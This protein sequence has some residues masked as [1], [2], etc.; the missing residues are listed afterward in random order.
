MTLL[1]VESELRASA[2][3]VGL[4]LKSVGLGLLLAAALLSPGCGSSAP[5]YVHVGES[6]SSPQ[7]ALVSGLDLASI[8]RS[9]R[10]QDDLYRFANG[11]WLKTV[12]I[13][14]DEVNAGPVVAIEKRVTQDLKEVVDGLLLTPHPAGSDEAK[15]VAL[16]QSFVDEAQLETVGVEPV[17]A[18][19]EALRQITTR[20]E[21]A[22]TWG[23]FSG[24]WFSGIF[25]VGVGPDPET[26]QVQSLYLSPTGLTLSRVYYL[27]DHPVHLEARRN[28][29]EYAT[30]M[31]RAAEHPDPEAGARQVLEIQTALA[32]AFPNSAEQNDQQKNNIRISTT[33]LGEVLAPFEWQ[34][35]ARA[36]GLDQ[37][38]ELVIGRLGYAE[39][40]GEVYASFEVEAWKSYLAFRL[41]DRYSYFMN[42]ATAGQRSRFYSALSGSTDAQP[43]WEM[44]LVGL[45]NMMGSAL[46]RKYVERHFSAAARQ[47]METMV[48]RLLAATREGLLEQTWFSESTRREALEKL[49]KMRVKIGYPDEWDSYE[50]LQV[51]PTDLVGNARRYFELVRSETLAEEGAPVDRNRW[52]TNPQT[53]NA[54]YDR[55]TNEMIFPAAFLQSPVFDLEADD[56][57]NYG[58][59]GTVIGHEIGHA[60]DDSG[61]LY[62]SEGAARDWWTAADRATYEAL[63]Q[64]LIDQFNGYLALPDLPVDGE[65]T[66]GE[67]LAD[68]MGL[69]SA[70]RA[71]EASLEGREAPVLD[72]FTG[73]QRFFLSYAQKNLL[74]FRED[75]LRLL[76]SHDEH[77]PAEFRVNGPLQHVDAF[78]EAF[79]VRPG[80]AMY[81]AP[82]KRVRFW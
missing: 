80:D 40:I 67:N 8:D 3:E 6:V 38:A 32:G 11:S 49:D 61:S 48:A 31:L 1:T 82:E 73:A 7:P 76:L 10:P 54:F 70:Y 58:A 30:G 28:L 18:P 35:Y 33:R 55:S 20:E 44:A 36:S 64:R 39:R 66:L 17:R 50:K 4:K 62:D 75:E 57:A 25:S 56:A 78:Y 81:L 14:E 51:S 43:R 5:N 12:Q 71:Y 52:T 15:L 69:V 2:L 27:E 63:S 24:I 37:S 79:D 23:E 47:K 77:A 42:A 41:M 16:Y 9:V 45:N 65:L 53:V 68:L 22:R 46:G 29:V 19:L 74:I 59:I 21:L 60:F 13:P 34:V 26:P 72:G